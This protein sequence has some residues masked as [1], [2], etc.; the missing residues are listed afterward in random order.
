MC[1]ICHASDR[2]TFFVTPR[3]SDHCRLQSLCALGTAA[4]AAPLTMPAARA[5]LRCCQRRTPHQTVCDGNKECGVS[6]FARGA[7]GGPALEVNTARAVQEKHALCVSK[8]LHLCLTTHLPVVK[9]HVAVGQQ[10]R[11]QVG[12]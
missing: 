6:V 3:S 9:H 12:G 5:T 2:R 11:H 10:I 7:G 4:A 1:A 8:S